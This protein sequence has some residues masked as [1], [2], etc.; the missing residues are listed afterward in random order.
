[1]RTRIVSKIVRMEKSA[2]VV[3]FLDWLFTNEKK[4][5]FSGFVVRFALCRKNHTTRGDARDQLCATVVEI[6]RR[7][8]KDPQPSYPFCGGKKFTCSRRV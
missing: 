3:T 2:L 8:Q 1:M 7:N 4:I 5:M 6:T